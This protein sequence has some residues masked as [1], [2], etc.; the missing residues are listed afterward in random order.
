[1]PPVVACSEERGG[2]VLLL[3]ERNYERCLSDV[4]AGSWDLKTK[5]LQLSS[6]LWSPTFD[7]NM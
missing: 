3:P 1:M 5:H 7:Q 4:F 2:L 6:K